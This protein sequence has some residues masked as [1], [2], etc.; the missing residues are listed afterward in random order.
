MWSVDIL[1]GGTPK[2]LPYSQNGSMIYSVDGKHA[3][4]ALTHQIR[5]YFVST[6]QC[7]KTIDIDLDELIEM[8]MESSSSS[9]LLLFKSTGEIIT[10]NWKERLAQPV[11]LSHQLTLDSSLLSVVHVT[12]EYY[13][14]IIGKKDKK[15]GGGSPHT[16]TLVKVRKAS[17][18][19]TSPI[20]EAKNVLR[21]SYSLNSSK[22]AFVTS[23]NQILLVDLSNH[24]KHEDTEEGIETEVISFPYKSK[25]TCV[26]VS[27]DS[28]IALGTI[29]GPIQIIYGGLNS[30]KPQGLLKWH[31]DQV[32][33]LQ[34]TNDNTYLISGGLEKVLVF[35]QL[36]T[37]KTQFLP[38]LNGTIERISI[39][40]NKIDY[41][42]LMLDSNELLAISA[43]DL[44]S[45]LSITS[46]KPKF[47]NDIASTLARSTKKYLKQ[48]QQFDLTKLKYDYTS[49]FEV[50]GKSNHLYF[51][52]ESSI[53]AYDVI[54]NE[55]LFVQN[56]AP[57]ISTG[58]VRS[59]AKL[60]DPS[61]SLLSFTNDGD[62]MCTFDTVS[63]SE[64]DNL[65]S[66]NDKQYALK[67]WRFIENKNDSS[68]SNS[69]TKKNGAGSWELS[70]KIID[71]HGDSNPIVS[72][73]AAPSSYYD[74]LAYLTVDSKGGLRLW[75]PRDV[76]TTTS[77]NNKQQQ[78]TAWTIRK[79]RP[80]FAQSSSD[81]IDICWSRDGSLIVL[82]YEY[83]LIPIVT[84]T[85]E[86]VLPNDFTIPSVS[87]SPIKSVSIIDNN[88]IV[89][90]KSRISSFNLLTGQ[91][92]ELVAAVNAPKQNIAINQLTKSICLAIN[93]YDTTKDAALVIKSK[94]VVFDPK[95]L[96]PID[97]RDYHTGISCVRSY[98]SSFIF[99][100]LDSRV[101]NFLSTTSSVDDQGDDDIQP[102]ELT[103]AVKSMLLNAHAT[104][105]IINNR[106]VSM[107]L[108]NISS[109]DDDNI[110]END[111]ISK[112]VDVH[113]FQPVFENT[114]GVQLETLFDRIVKILH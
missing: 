113:T 10:I 28:T 36:E 30:A 2:V 50:N 112:L 67:F 93:Y 29:S 74:G 103:S 27:N 57:I 47:S 96:E 65:L 5:V 80:S 102:Q 40:K 22:I 55:Q 44:I 49:I 32:K 70:T 26:A 52:N 19:S 94:L 105:D 16:R 46:I 21:Y 18:S 62:W 88:L 95:S 38:R 101:G 7:I 12:P 1:T 72:I 59:E 39:D 60:L 6:R 34:F 110:A 54:R 81:S 61:I 100:D 98:N 92:N 114:E 69:T 109:H 51:P 76:T 104:A 48:P 20:Y 106:N 108:K 42:N 33:A 111:T 41:Y 15:L 23:D 75:R 45:R 90:S 86:M 53:Q 99:V 37:T 24:Y 56:C 8:R 58:K 82:G 79:S 31:I 3:I 43:I 17:S 14:M 9:H 84:S 73:V 25:I 35:W 85:F 71:P 78:Q 89:L 4:V 68:S 97:V 64:V 91:L 107:K 87:G 66:K 77:T 63:T 83:S 11:L 13:Y